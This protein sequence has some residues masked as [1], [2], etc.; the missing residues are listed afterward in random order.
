MPDTSRIIE[1]AV[2]Q[3]ERSRGIPLMHIIKGSLPACASFRQHKCAEISSCSRLDLSADEQPARAAPAPVFNA[4]GRP[5]NTF[6]RGICFAA[7]RVLPTLQARQIHAGHLFWSD[8]GQV[9]SLSDHAHSAQHLVRSA[10]MCS[11]ILTISASYSVT[12][13]CRGHQRA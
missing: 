3:T 13:A 6:P 9:R 11:S 12:A 4:Q 10:P 8:A 1:P 5:L 2:W 7:A